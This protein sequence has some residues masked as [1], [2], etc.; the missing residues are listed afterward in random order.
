MR[1][2]WMAV[3][4]AMLGGNTALAQVGGMS[5]PTPGVAVT[6]PLGM[7]GASQPGTSVGPTGI[8]L[9]ATE[10][11]SPG[12]SPMLTDPTG[13]MAITCSAG[14]TSTGMSGGI[15][16]VSTYDGGGLAVGGGMGP[17]TVLPGSA[18]PCRTVSTGTATALAPSRSPSGVS[19]TG[20]PLGSFEIGNAGVSPLLTHPTPTVSSAIGS[21]GPSPLMLGTP[22][23]PSTSV[24][25]SSPTPGTGFATNQN[26]MPCGSIVTSGPAMFC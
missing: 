7:S 25:P 3:A 17:G 22:T 20:I 23:L 2:M 15:S 13:M 21:P 9:G 24:S 12:I 26:T 5:V 6:S 14:S 11:A 16:R 8:P 18:A 19:R 1:R 10:L 4:I